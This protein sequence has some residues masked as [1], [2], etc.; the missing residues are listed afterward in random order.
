MPAPRTEPEPPPGPPAAP[1]APAPRHRRRLAARIRALVRAIRENDEDDIREAMLR[2]SQSR[3]LLAPL[4][5]LVGGVVLLFQGF[6]LV[7]FNWRLTLVQ[8]LPAMWIW[9]AM[10]DL[11]IHVLHGHSFH[12]IRGPVLIPIW[13]AIIGLTMASLFLNAVFAFAISRPGRAD[14]RPAV[15]EARDHLMAILGW[16]LALGAPLAFATTVAPRYPRPWFGISL[17][18]VV[19]AMMVCYVAVPSRLIGVKPARSRRDKLASTAVSGALSATVCT[20]PYLL[21]RLG[22]LMLGSPSLF[23]PGIFLLVVGATLQAGATGA[24]RAIKMS[25]SL[26]TDPDGAAAPAPAASGP[27]PD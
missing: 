17:S 25:V 1:G 9:L 12:V 19:G 15:T 26:V 13:M 23:I 14:I 18:L 7:V 16:G 21:G 10:L 5:L 11:K 4:A 6:R 8:V 27:D 2:L 22:I 20:P 24:V 3:R